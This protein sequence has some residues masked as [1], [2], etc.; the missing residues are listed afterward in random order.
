[1]DGSIKIK[2]VNLTTSDQDGHA[3]SARIINKSRNLGPQVVHNALQQRFLTSRKANGYSD[4]LA[5]IF[6][7]T[8]ASHSQPNYVVY[9]SSHHPSV[10]FT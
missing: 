1:M 8:P 5:P 2:M 3:S 9:A 6:S 10:N 4:T 7:M